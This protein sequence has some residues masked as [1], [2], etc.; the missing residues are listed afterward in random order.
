MTDTTRAVIAEGAGGPEVLRVVETARPDP[1]PGQLLIEVHAAGV[2]RPDVMQRQ[3]NYP[4]P[5]GAS[6]VF[7]LELAG[8][9]AALGPD[10]TGFEIGDRVM[11]LVHS[12][13]YADWAVLDAPIAIPVPEGLSMAEAGAVPET[14]F[15][16]WSN[17]FERAALQPGET[18]LIHGGTSGI[19]TTAIQLARALGST[20]IVT[21]GSDAKCEA[22]LKLGADHAINYRTQDFVEVARELTGGTGPDVILDMIGGPYMQRNIDLLAPDGRISQIAFQQGS[23]A[24]VDFLPLLMKRGTLTASTLRARPVEMKAKLA[25]ALTEHVVPLLASGKVRPP[26]DST[27]PLEDVASAHARMDGGE[28]VGKIVLLM[29]SET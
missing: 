27:F 3:G 13:A 1:G 12:G 23:K 15:T 25:R 9:V 19:G 21:A 26:V 16:V 11:G 22:A 8:V 17:V 20:V 24:E 10:V 18:L 6:D 28:H 5:P 7:G 14:F 2:N 4:P 29:K